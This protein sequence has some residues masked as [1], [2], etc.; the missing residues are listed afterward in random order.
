[1]N[2]L[3]HSS[4]RKYCHA[5]LVE[6]CAR[7]V[8]TGDSYVLVT[9]NSVHVWLGESSNVLEKSKAGIVRVL[10]PSLEFHFVLHSFILDISISPLHSSSSLLL[11]GAPDYS[12][13]T[14]SEATRW[15]ASGNYKWKTCPRSLHGGLSL[16]RTCDL[17]D[18]RHRTYHWATTPHECYE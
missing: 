3:W 14:V 2:C 16:T 9:S 15:S 1:M 17:P 4:G 12:I 13:D 8:N 6:P 10:F 11:R 18:A 7:S 5:R